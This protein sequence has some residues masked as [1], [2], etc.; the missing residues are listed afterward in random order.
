MEATT[1]VLLRAKGASQTGDHASKA[2]GRG[3]VWSEEGTE[4]SRAGVKP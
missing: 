3:S 4:G 2:Y 1:L